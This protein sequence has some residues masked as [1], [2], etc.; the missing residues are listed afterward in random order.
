MSSTERQI[1]VSGRDNTSDLIDCSHTGSKREFKTKQSVLSVFKEILSQFNIDVKCELLPVPIVENIKIDPGESVFEVL[2]K[3]ARKLGLILQS[4][5]SGDL[6][7]TKISEEYS[8]IDLRDGI[9]FLESYSSFNHENCFSHYILKGRDDHHKPIQVELKDGN[10]KRYRPLEIINS[11]VISEEEAKKKL[12]WELTVR[13]ARATEF[14]ASVQGWTI[15]QK[16]WMPNHIYK[17]CAPS[18]GIKDELLLL[19]SCE[20]Y[21]NEEGTT[22]ELG[23]SKAGSFK[24]EPKIRPTENIKHFGY[25]R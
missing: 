24:L 10:I 19:K 14:F 11:G 12:K 25:G 23:F 1:E 21:F 22:T 13:Q 9:D 8:N 18:N 17:I 15:N 7:I 16:P 4:S 2:E 3:I 5:G 6:V 20:F